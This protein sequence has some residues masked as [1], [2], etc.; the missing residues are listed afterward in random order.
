MKSLSTVALLGGLCGALAFAS[1]ALAVDAPTVNTNEGASPVGQTTAT[2]SGTVNPNGSAVTECHVDYGTSFDY[3]SQASCDALP[4]DGTSDVTVSASLSSLTPGTTYHIRF[5]ATNAGGTTRAF[6]ADFTT[7]ALPAPT[8]VTGDATTVMETNGRAN[9]A[10]VYGTVNPNG[11]ETQCRFQ[12]GQ[13]TA[14]GLDFPCEDVSP[15]SGT[16]PVTV[17]A[18]LSGL[19]A[20]TTYHY[21]LIAQNASGETIGADRTFTSLGA[22]VPPPPP[23]RTPALS[24]PSSVTVRSGRASFALICNGGGADCR[25][26]LTF[27]A[28]VKRGHRTTTITVGKAKVNLAVGESAR[29]TVKLSSAA[30]RALKKSHSLRVSVKGVGRA[31]TI[32]YKR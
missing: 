26:T 28:K 21:R 10:T 20:N 7:T 16:S 5:V 24:V 2:V 30:R 6:D 4:G 27:T 31:H 3:G 15:G 13:T 8:V 25:G 17:H 9:S 22:F 12:A 29:V 23:A 14:Y 11:L 19:F 1:P 32:K 18:S